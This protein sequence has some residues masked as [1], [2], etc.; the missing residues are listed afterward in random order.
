MKYNHVVI[1]LDPS[2][3]SKSSVTVDG[4]RVACRR[5]WFE[6]DG[7]KPPIVTLELIAAVDVETSVPDYQLTGQD[8]QET[9]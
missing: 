9:E 4:V 5:I 7:N 3:R 8:E 6:A 2:D 1:H